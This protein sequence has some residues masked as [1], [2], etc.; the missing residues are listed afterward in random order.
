[1]IYIGLILF[2]P[3]NPAVV[4]GVCKEQCIN[5]KKYSFILV[6]I[7]VGSPVVLYSD[8][9]MYMFLLLIYKQIM[10]HC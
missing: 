5:T 3:Q 8:P 2:I 6:T 10:I 4:T 9:S 7:I 1:M